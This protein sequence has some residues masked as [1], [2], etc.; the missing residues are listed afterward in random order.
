MFSTWYEGPD[1]AYI[2]EGRNIL[3]YSYSMF[4][5]S[6]GHLLIY[7]RYQVSNGKA[8]VLGYSRFPT[9]SENGRV[10]LYYRNFS[11][12]INKT[13]PEFLDFLTFLLLEACA[14]QLSCIRLVL[15]SRLD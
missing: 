10:L 3:V 9:V 2:S 14:T 13:T 11:R 7:P 1:S 6:I 8:V 12:T 15:G 4:T 5:S